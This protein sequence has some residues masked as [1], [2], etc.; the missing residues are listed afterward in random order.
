MFSRSCD[1]PPC[2]GCCRVRCV[3]VFFLSRGDPPRGP[4]FGL[5]CRLSSLLPTHQ[6]DRRRVAS[7]PSALTVLNSSR[8][9]SLWFCDRSCDARFSTSFRVFRAKV[10]TCDYL[11]LHGGVPPVSQRLFRIWN[12]L[13]TVTITSRALEKRYYIGCVGFQLFSYNIVRLKF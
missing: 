13:Q 4:F 5:N 6:D 7:D 10:V 1:F 2:M 12:D 11:H 9:R 8:E 3:V